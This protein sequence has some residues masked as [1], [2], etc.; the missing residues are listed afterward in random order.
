M[1][2]LNRHDELLRLDRAMQHPGGFAALW[3]RRRVG[4]SRLLIEWTGRN[5]GLYAVADQS[6]PIVQ[7]RFLAAAIAQRFPGFADVEYPNWHALLTRVAAEADRTGWRGPLVLDQFPYLIGPDRGLLG[8]MQNWLDS[9][10]RALRIVV[11]GSS[12]RMMNDAVLKASSPLYG[13]AVEVFALRP[14]R[15]GHIADAFPALGHRAQLTIYAVWGGMPRYWEL[16]APFEADIDDSVDS[17]VLD[18][19]GPLHGEPSRLL[20]EETPPAT[21]LRPLLDVMGAGAHRLTEIGGRLGR[22]AP[23][24]SRPLA[25]LVE[26]GIVR[27]EIPFGSSATSGKRSLYRIDDPF[28]RLWFRVVAP[29]RSALAESPPE[30]RLQYWRRSRPALEA[31]AWED[32]SRM[33]VPWLHRVDGPLAALGP[34]E[35]ARRYWHGNAPEIDVVA[36]SVDG[37]RLLVGESRL[38]CAGRW[39]SRLDD[40][41]IAAAFPEERGREVVRVLF[42]PCANEADL[43][44]ESIIVVDARTVLAALR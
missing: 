4:K 28:L 8:T 14:L 10:E 9:P 18:P 27:R 6:A 22:P 17:L 1:R 33:C 36:R 3:G 34:F 32:L 2:F 7:R 44:D 21:A 43:R 38:S 12:I 19:A 26:M 23:S 20:E 15:P 13:Q 30:T 39:P 40:R 24:L 35:G 42:T 5:G 29:H 41:A 31:C 25:T 16:A 11:C 37:K